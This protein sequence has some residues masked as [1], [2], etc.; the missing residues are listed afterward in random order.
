[1]GYLLTYVRFETCAAIN[2]EMGVFSDEKTT[3]S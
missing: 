2:V 3:V 1:M